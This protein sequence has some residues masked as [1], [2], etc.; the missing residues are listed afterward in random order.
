MS[1]TEYPKLSG[2]DAEMQWVINE[3]QCATDYILTGI[4][5]V[6]ITKVCGIVVKPDRW[7]RPRIQNEVFTDQES[8][9][10]SLSR[11]SNQYGSAQ[12]LKIDFGQLWSCSPQSVNDFFTFIKKQIDGELVGIGT[13]HALLVIFLR[14]MSRNNTFESKSS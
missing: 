2:P 11:Y 8:L 10:S 14:A 4:R 1:L 13:I 12:T 3:D 5:D 7:R 9:Q 6:F